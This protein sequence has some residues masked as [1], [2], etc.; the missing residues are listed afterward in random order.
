M[1]EKGN[2]IIA[3]D[4]VD[5]VNASSGGLEIGDIGIAALPIDESKQKR[6]YLNGQSIS[7]EQ[8]AAFTAKLRAA[9][10]LYPSLAC[11]ESEWQA[12]KSS[13]KVGQVGKFVIND[14]TGTIRLPCIVKLQ[15]TLSLA[16]IG[17]IKDAGLPN[18]EG[19]IAGLVENGR[20]G[21]GAFYNLRSVSNQGYG[22]NIV[23]N[24]G[25]N[26]S[27][28]KSNPIYGNSNTVQEEAIQYPYFIQVA[29][30]GPEAEIP[31]EILY[32]K[33]NTDLSNIT[34][35]AKGNVVSWG[36]PDYSAAVSKS[37]GSSAPKDGWAIAHGNNATVTYSVNGVSVAQGNWW[38]NNWSGNWNLQ[39]MVS[40]GDVVSGGSW[41]FIPC[42]GV[43]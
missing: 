38:E 31:N 39:I 43:D 30:S 5:A 19:Y 21:T 14:T 18:I 34:S 28:S 37:S 1:L 24:Y 9:V 15:G 16:N 3:Q 8:F 7:Q 33:L 12:I 26:F 17:N 40:A 2:R 35:G 13:S 29:S 4:V 20:A 36:M 27:A 6:R 11:T 25:V 22:T 32:T 23:S 10:A 41:K 42:K